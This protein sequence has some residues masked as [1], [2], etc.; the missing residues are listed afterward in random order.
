MKM[1]AWVR[2]AVG[3][4]VGIG[5]ISF[6]AEAVEFVIVTLIHGAPTM[7]PAAYFEVRNQL[8][9]LVLKVFYNAAA[10][11]AGGYVSAWIAGRKEVVVGVALLILQTVALL[12]A[13]QSPD[14][15]LWTP[16]WMWIVLILTMPPAILL[17]AHQRGVR[18][19]AVL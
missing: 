8:S 11:F 2:I 18:M 12:W 17:G 14:L 4:V 1:I 6:I 5:V 19:R 9:V 15:R 16:L 3:I 13:M 7:D 10:G